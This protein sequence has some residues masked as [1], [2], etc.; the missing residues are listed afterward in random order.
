MSV[1]S[2]NDYDCTVCEVDGEGG[3]LLCCE[4]CPRVYHLGCLDPP[5]S[6][7][8]SSDWFCPHCAPA[9]RLGDVEKVLA[10]RPRIPVNPTVLLQKTCSEMHLH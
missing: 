8:P 6:E 10:R 9:K 4:L 1:V 7:V 3:E 2:Q 5:L